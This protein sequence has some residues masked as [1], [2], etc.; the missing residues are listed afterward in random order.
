MIHFLRS[1]TFHD[2]SGLKIDIHNHVLPGIDDG[3]VDIEES[4]SIRNFLADIGLDKLIY[5][6]HI[7]RGVHNN[8]ATSILNSFTSLMD[9]EPY[10]L[11]FGADSFAAEYMLDDG[12]KLLMES[13]EPLLCQKDSK[14]LVE[15]PL[16]FKSQLVDELLFE[17][18]I[19]GYQPIIA[20]P[21]RY[22]YLHNQLNYFE[23]LVSE[24][25]MLQLNLLSL[26]GYYTK[27]AKIM[28]VELL[29]KELV[30]FL[31]TDIH[32]A[33]QFNMFRKILCSNTW[34]NWYTY[35]FKNKTLLQS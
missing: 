29:K 11:N 4:M 27:Q 26:G 24:G 35:P 6:P 31:A 18:L 10:Q 7:Y 13:G 21:E 33:S 5:T 28:A 2:L 1:P 32:H 17:L 9:Y 3:S 15:F 8:T 14:I 25:C 34:N 30:D 22:P 16:N 12:F 20:H 19:K 23:K